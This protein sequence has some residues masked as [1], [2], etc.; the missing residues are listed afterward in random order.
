MFVTDPGLQA[1]VEY[2]HGG[3]AALATI[4]DSGYRP[5][6]CSV[7]PTSGNLAVANYET[8]R[9]KPG[10]VAIYKNASGTPAFYDAGLDGKGPLTCGYDD[11]GNLLVATEY[12]HGSYKYALFAMLPKNG[13]TFGKIDLSM[14]SQSP[15]EFVTNVQ[16]DGEYWAITDNGNIQRYTIDGSGKATYQSTVDLADNWDGLAQLWLANTTRKPGEA[17]QMAAAQSADVFYWK[18][19]S[20]GQPYATIKDDLAAPYGVTMSLATKK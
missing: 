6:A 9:N 15:F 12:S 10:N 7:D 19:P 3:K 18:Y 5:Y 20:G 14:I 16:W 1:I 13:H 11:S 4:K 17:N 8:S 2:A